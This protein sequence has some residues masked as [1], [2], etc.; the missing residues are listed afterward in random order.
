M[1]Y[2][3]PALAN[4][5]SVDLKFLLDEVKSVFSKEIQEKEIM[6][7]EE[8]L[9]PEL[10]FDEQH[11]R[12]VLINLFSNSIAVINHNGKITVKSYSDSDFINL[13][14]Y[15][16]GSGVSPEWVD[17]IFDPFFTKNKN[18]NGLGLA[19]CKKLCHENDAIITVRNEV[20]G[21]TFTIKKRQR[22]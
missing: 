6:V 11:L 18:G 15:D 13:D 4:P 17:K 7:E 14:V 8:V 3:R 10:V 19:I 5:V 20:Q 22:A 1:E 16:N 21:C 2:G 9:V 12:Q